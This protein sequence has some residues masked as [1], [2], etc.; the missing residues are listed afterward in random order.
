MAKVDE[1]RVHKRF[2]I[3]Q[4]ITLT[5]PKENYINAVGINISKTG[6]LCKTDIFLDS[7]TRIF[8]MLSIPIGNDNKSFSC[9]AIVIWCQ[10][11]NEEYDA[12]LQF[13]ELFDEQK[14]II[15]NYINELEVNE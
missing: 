14:E 1:R 5:F 2:D 4:A 8:L 7:Y 12:G 6:L 15:Q 11:E 13:V 10:K 3:N 9:E